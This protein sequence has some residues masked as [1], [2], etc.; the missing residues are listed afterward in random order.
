VKFPDDL[1]P[2]LGAIVIRHELVHRNG[3]REDG[4]EN[5]KESDIRGVMAIANE[6][7]DHIENEWLNAS[8]P[9]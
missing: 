1:K 5:I 6:L 7:V 3:K 2:L 8:S 9:F 4:S